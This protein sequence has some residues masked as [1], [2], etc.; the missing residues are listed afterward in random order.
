MAEC[1]MMALDEGINRVLQEHLGDKL[2]WTLWS[3]DTYD[4]CFHLSMSHKES[5]ILLQ[6]RSPIHPAQNMM[7][8]L[9]GENH[10]PP[11][12]LFAKLSED[13]IIYT[14]SDP[15]ITPMVKPLEEAFHAALDGLYSCE[16]MYFRSTVWQQNEAYFVQRASRDE[17]LKEILRGCPAEELRMHQ[18]QHNLDLKNQGYYL[19]LWEMH[20]IE[21]AE[22][23]TYKDIYNFL[24]YAMVRECQ[25][26]INGLNG[27]EVFYVNLRLLCVIINDLHI[28]SKTTHS[29]R[30]AKTIHELARATGCKTATRFLSD[31]LPN[32]A[33][34]RRGYEDYSEKAPLMFFVRDQE[35]MYSALIEQKRKNVTLAEVQQSLY[36]ITRYLHYDIQNPKLS[37]VLKRLYLEILKPSMSFSKYYFSTAVLMSELSNL[38]DAFDEEELSSKLN[39]NLVKFTSIEEQYQNILEL[40]LK[41]QKQISSKHKTKHTILLRALNYIE[42]NYNQGITVSD[43]VKNLYVSGVYLNKVFSVELNMSVIEYLIQFRIKQAMK[44]LA[45][46]NDPVYVVAEKVGFKD[47][48]HFSK[49]FK[50][51]VCRTPVEYRNEFRNE[52][53]SENRSMTKK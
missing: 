39:P 20:M 44:L 34:I 49:T 30:L 48:R 7:I 13:R 18:Q 1:I 40:V 22:H 28:N 24:G 11:I 4:A 21:F 17:A 6:M 46:T 35:I 25:T 10:R 23:R 47:A 16:R 15:E 3:A 43:I 42:E 45:D 27:G 41:L 33:T 5:A 53:R 52:N 2:N 12:L 14:V 29:H 51:I 50:R 19:Y 26:A 32:L 31:Y 37:A 8:D 9:Q 36:Q 38:Y